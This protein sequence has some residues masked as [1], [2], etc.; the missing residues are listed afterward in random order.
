MNEITKNKSYYL[1][2]TEKTGND[3]FIHNKILLAKLIAISL[4]NFIS[5]K[6]NF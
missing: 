2:Y 3:A 4:N 5:N 6:S 1:I